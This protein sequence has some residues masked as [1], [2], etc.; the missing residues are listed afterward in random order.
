MGMTVNLF[1]KQLSNCKIHHGVQYNGA[2]YDSQHNHKKMRHTGHHIEEKNA[3]ECRIL[4]FYCYTECSHAR[5]RVDQL[6]W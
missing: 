1:L 5:W 2:Q 4:S 3:T 6:K